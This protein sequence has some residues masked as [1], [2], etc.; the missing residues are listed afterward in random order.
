MT[1]TT[2]QDLPTVTTS[3]TGWGRTSASTA[4]VLATPDVDLIAR[5]VAAVAERNADSPS[6]LVRGIVARGLGRSY[7][8][9]AQNAGGIVVD[10]SL[11][12]I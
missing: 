7:G 4:Q 2:A 1:T 12:H 11:I 5:A 9:V 3:L 6:H 10:L 8:D